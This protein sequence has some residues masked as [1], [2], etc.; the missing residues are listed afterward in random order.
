MIIVTE[1]ISYSMVKMCQSIVMHSFRYNSQIK[2]FWTHVDRNF[3]RVLV[4]GTC[5]QGL[6]GTFSYPLYSEI[7]LSH[8]ASDK[9]LEWKRQAVLHS[10]QT[11][12]TQASSGTDLTTAQTYYELNLPRLAH[13][14]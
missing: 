13:S 1:N 7:I 10:N 6:S 12:E 9:P 8:N 3:S 2:C 4:C 11:T 5:A 14:R